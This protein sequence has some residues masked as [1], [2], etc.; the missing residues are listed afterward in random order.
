M[1]EM[2]VFE[3]KNAHPDGRHPECPADHVWISN[4]P[5]NPTYHEGLGWLA[6][7]VGNYLKTYL[8]YFIRYVMRFLFF[9]NRGNVS[10]FDIHAQAYKTG[11]KL[12]KIKRSYIEI[13][14]EVV[15]LLHFHPTTPVSWVSNMIL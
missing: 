14:F 2:R 15:S 7:K 5:G 11:R 3:E 13:G 8:S 6:K 10:V 9:E 1:S 4:Y 12:R